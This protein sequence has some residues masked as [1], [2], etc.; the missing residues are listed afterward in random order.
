LS[1][2]KKY[3]K[4]TF[5]FSFLFIL[6]I[7]FKELFRVSEEENTIFLSLFF[8]V[9]LIFATLFIKAKYLNLYKCFFI[10]FLFLFMLSLSSNNVSYGIQKSNLGLVSPL[11]CFML[12]T[13]INWHRENLIKYF[14]FIIFIITV[15]GI[16]YKLNNGFFQRSVSFGL[17]GSITFGWLSG[18]GFLAAYLDHKKS[19]IDYFLIVYFFLM[20]LWTGS[21]GPL[22]S[23][24]IIT[25]YFSRK[26]LFT[27]FKNFIIISFIFLASYFFISNYLEEIRSVRMILE[28][29]TSQEEYISG[30]GAGSFGTRVNYIDDSKILFYQNPFLGVGF[31]GWH[32]QNFYS[33]HKYPHNIIFELISE[34]GLIGITLFLFLINK[35]WTTKN[36]FGIIGIYSLISL[37]F[38]GDFSYFRYAFFPLLISY[39]I[40]KN[41]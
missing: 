4:E 8:W 40:N 32:T 29:A 27:S 10:F 16:L 31:G 11:F 7:A 9:L 39:F 12:F 19:K 14:T 6:N 21:K 18:M 5:L 22:F 35:L 38:S 25:L 2:K 1:I 28:L 20:I 33:D 15:I 37:Q 36:I 3:L 30:K 24:S 17:F 34:V 41:T 13:R 23:V 26:I